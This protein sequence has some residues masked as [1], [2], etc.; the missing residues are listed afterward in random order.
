MPNALEL[1]LPEE[2][3]NDF[4]ALLGR[5]TET[6]TPSLT[7]TE[8]KDAI[9][10]SQ[11]ACLVIDLGELNEL[12]FAALLAKRDVA[13]TALQNFSILLIQGEIDAKT[14]REAAAS[15]EEEEGDTEEV[16]DEDG[17]EQN[18]AVGKLA[19]YVREN[20]TYFPALLRAYH[21]RLDRH[22]RLA[23]L[24]ARIVLTRAQASMLWD[25]TLTRIK[26]LLSMMGLEGVFVAIDLAAK[27][28]PMVGHCLRAFGTIA[29]PLVAIYTL[30]RWIIRFATNPFQ[31]ILNGVAKEL[32]IEVPVG[33]PDG[34]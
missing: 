7:A 26:T 18:T 20:Y 34:G 15:E 11:L 32:E 10:A 31:R 8:M 24:H 1:M 9:L 21:R 13:D 29:T 4:V 2:A 14:A 22:P 16:E 19:N 6:A 17:E 30:V 3:I 23:R 25:Q 5:L 27:R 12:E 33:D 28:N